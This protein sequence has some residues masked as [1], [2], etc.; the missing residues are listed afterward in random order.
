MRREEAMR[1][2]AA[3]GPVVNR[4]LIEGGPLPQPS[5]FATAGADAERARVVAWLREDAEALEGTQTNLDRLI[6]EAIRECADAIERGE[7]WAGG[8]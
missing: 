1:E 2:A 6:A 3:L 7:H 5:D 4:W 8:E